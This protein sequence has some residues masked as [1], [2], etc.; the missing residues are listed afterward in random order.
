MHYVIGDVH[1]C[2]TEL[3]DLL[4][5]IE[6]QDTDAKYIFVGDFIDRGECVWEVLNWAMEHITSD[7]KYQSV[8]GNH[9]QMAIEWWKEY[10]YWYEQRGRKE[11]RHADF[12]P[13]TMYDISNILFSNIRAT[14]SG[15]FHAPEDF[16][17]VMQFFQ[18]L[19]YS[20]CQEIV[21]VAGIPMKFRIVHA[22]YDYSYPEMSEQQHDINIYARNFWGAQYNWNNS[23][24]EIVVCGHTPTIHR[25]FNLRNTQDRPGFICYRKN[26][27]NVDCG[28][29]FHSFD[30]MVGSGCKAP[31]M[32]G[33]ICLET[34]EELYPYTLEERLRANIRKDIENGKYPFL[35]DE[36]SINEWIEVGVKM[37]TET[38][39][40]NRIEENY[41][42]NEICKRL[43][44]I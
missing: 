36:D 24:D 4:N 2:Y 5:K 10:R 42:R 26:T 3:M 44:C 6:E 29:V 34:M 35:K 23:E 9:E 38:Y 31:C 30:I 13:N 7:G 40:G 15:G 41:Y 8:R 11:K 21:S 28:C 17:T 39:G 22:A 37:Y 19:P 25:D 20:K 1:G 43:G 16:E 12:P 18:S 14:G 27:I 33:A 32:L